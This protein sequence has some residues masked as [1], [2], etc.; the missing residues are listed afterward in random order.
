MGGYRMDIAMVFA[1]LGIEETKEE[2]K[3][4]QAY[5]VKLLENNPEDNPE[6]FRRLREAYEQALDDI[7]VSKR[8]KE[9]GIEEELTPVGRWMK[10]VEEV[11]NRLSMRL[12]QKAWRELFQDEVCLDLEDGEEAKWQLF[13]FL[14]EHYRLSSEI[15]RLLDEVFEVQKGRREFEEHLPVGF[16]NYMVRKMQDIDGEDDFLYRWTEGEDT[17]DYDRFY[18]GLYELEEWIEKEK[19][20]EAEQTVKVLEQLGIDHPYYR[21]AKARL[22][23]LQG[24]TDLVQT[25][26]ELIQTY[27]ESARIQLDGIEILWKCDRKKEAI[28]V[29]RR[30]GEVFGIAYLSEKYLA[31]YEKEQGNLADAIRHCLQALQRAEDSGL[32]EILKELDRAYIQACEEKFA[33][34]TLEAEDM[35]Y[36]CSSY[37][38]EERAQEGLDLLFHYPE[39]KEKIRNIHNVLS[40]LYFHAEKYQEAVE[41]CR[42]WRE[43]AKKEILKEQELE[44]DY[45][46]L[47]ST[48][49]CEGQALQ[50]MAEKL[51]GRDAVLAVYKEAEQVFLEA[52]SYAK[53]HQIT[54]YLR[55]KQNLLDLLLLENEFE[56]A[57]ALAD[58][59]LDQES[60]WFPALV[61]KQQACYELDRPQE[62]VDLFEQAKEIY[63]GFAPIYELAARVFIDYDRYSDAEEIFQQ[64]KEAS[65]ESLGLEMAK[66][67][68]ERVQCESE[69]EFRKVWKKAKELV[70]KFQKNPASR[71]EMAELYYEMAILEDCKSEQYS[72]KAEQ[73]IKKAI[74]LR[75]ND[76]L[77]GM[78][79]YYYTYARIM[80]N[81]ER[82][83]EA[84]KNY[85]IYRKNSEMTERLAM[86]MARCYHEIEEWEKAIFFY[87]EALSLNPKQPEANRKLAAIYRWLGVDKNSIIILRKALV[88]AEQQVV[89]C[90]DSAYDY[91][92]K[93][94]IG[95]LLGDLEQAMADAEKSLELEPD[96]SYG[97]LLKGRVLYY[98]EQYTMALTCFEEALQNL[99]NPKA[100]G[101]DMLGFAARCC[102]KMGDYA[103]AEVWY[104]K[105]M[106]LFEGEDRADCYW[107][108]IG[109]CEEQR[110][111]E[112]AFALL[113]E[114]YQKEVITE[115]EYVDYSI[116]LR[117]GLCYG[118]EQAKQLE[119]EA[120]QAAQKFDSIDAW[121]TLADL[122]FFYLGDREKALEIKQMVMERVE[123]EQVQWDHSNKYLERMQIYWERGETEEVNKWAKLYIQM[124]EKHYPILQ[125]E[126]PPIEQHL[127][128]P[129]Q[130]YRHLCKMISYWIFTGQM[131]LAK[132][133]LEEA[134]K[135]KMCR[136]CWEQ[137]CEDLIEAM[138]L[139]YEAIGE[140]ETAYQYW[141]RNWK[142]DPKDEMYY[143]KTKTLGE[144]LGY[145]MDWDEQVKVLWDRLNIMKI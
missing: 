140:L 61:Q 93:G 38:R 46:E 79:Y 55:I 21:V 144:Q 96:N 85:E 76:P 68:L 3:I 74:R 7:R 127:E 129:G 69:A 6:G 75:R 117:R 58:E 90:P 47:F 31:I 107:K 53:E 27:P 12:D 26:E 52:I 17:A 134:K 123:R 136:H 49:S 91:R 139:Y 54:A 36:V 48:Y 110:R 105:G 60:E 11:Y 115:E 95:R 5:H 4:R 94:N 99:E 82:Y 28:T 126:F 65:V 29:C 138:A 42:I 71:R 56:R 13:Q 2:E 98:T 35:R 22:A 120:Y 43:E 50:K 114:A 14:T 8:E 39:Y 103:Q 86:N 81:E 70:K 33:E 89:I 88:Y 16:V 23:L 41:E 72:G 34:G 121:E 113:K 145:S 101:H 77:R 44:E 30:F 106:D 112:E 142:K 125:E 111:L 9:E 51:V 19:V 131:E 97:W 57:I 64:A 18:A 24:R 119:Q 87:Q 143:Y 92:A 15:Y 1:I 130:G 37:I 20:A 108:L 102:R 109:L 132:E 118:K 128:E 32:E 135:R 137:E 62:V 124:I 133:K 104:R 40:V 84:V 141:Y 83:Q 100:Y 63:A 25:A 59:I 66:I 45:S 78:V 80:Q 116:D 10:R 73:Y 67:Y 122:Q